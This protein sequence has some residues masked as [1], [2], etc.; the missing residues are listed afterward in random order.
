MQRINEIAT[1]V[2]EALDVGP[3]LV[4]CQ[5]GLNRSG[6]VAARA[7]MLLDGR[8]AAQ[9]I[10]DV[11]RRSPVCLCNETFTNWLRGFDQ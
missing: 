7:L 8:S 9:A 4:H 1:E 3:T 2:V 6:L 5:A 10:N 11:R